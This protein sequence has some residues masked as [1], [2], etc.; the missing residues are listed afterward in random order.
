MTKH[1]RHTKVYEFLANANIS[2]A[3][4]FISYRKKKGF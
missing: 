4:A 2:S 1:I 3:H